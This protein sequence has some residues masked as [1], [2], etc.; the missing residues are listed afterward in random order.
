MRNVLLKLF[1]LA[2]LSL[3]CGFFDAN[4]TPT[5]VGHR[6]GAGYWPE[7]SRL[8]ISES[9]ARGWGGIEFDLALT[10][11]GIPV[12]NHDPWLNQKLCTRADG[13]AIGSEV[14]V[15]D[16]TL[17]E[18]H[19][20]YRCG[21]ARD[22]ATPDAMVKAD[23]HLTL[24]ELLAVAKDAPDTLLH[25]D[26]KFEPGLSL[27]AQDF[28]NAI[29]DR[30]VAAG[31]KNR[32]LYSSPFPEAIAAFEAKGDGITTIYTWPN[33]PRDK[34]NVAVALEAEA[35]R[36]VGASDLVEK[37]RSVGAD[38]ISVTWQVLD[39]RS[40]EEVQR[41]RLLVAVWTVNGTDGQQAYC[42]FPV[43]FLITDYPEAA[44]CR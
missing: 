39:R 23:T 38:G 31:L 44:P 5:V 9:L 11:D 34:S 27:P 6:G 33:F 19:E 10:K 30:V 4:G 17:E 22:D 21:G 24:D 32:I 3:S 2:A 41:A 40:A 25:V 14:L 42:K 7:N 20:G 36:T 28:A 26:L 8:A 1:P 35:T 12:L 29:V 16:L 18:L 13:S 43:D 15:K 37:I